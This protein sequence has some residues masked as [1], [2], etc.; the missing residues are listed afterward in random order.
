M[1]IAALLAHGGGISSCTFASKEQSTVRK[2]RPIPGIT[3]KRKATAIFLTAMFLTTGLAS[4]PASATTDCVVDNFTDAAGSNSDGSRTLRFCIENAS[5]AGDGGTI[6]FANGGVDKVI[7]L[8]SVLDRSGKGVLTIDGDQQITV[9][10]ASG[11]TDRLL[12]TDANI[13]ITGMTF[14]DAN[15]SSGSGGAI[16]ASGVVTIEDSLFDNN[17]ASS[18]GG[19]I[20][21]SVD[22]VVKNSRFTNNEAGDDGGAIWA[23]NEV[24]VEESTFTNN[25]AGTGSDNLG[26]AIYSDENDGVTITN[27]TFTQNEAGDDGGAI[28]ANGDVSVENSTFSLNVSGE[29]GGAIWVDGDMDIADGSRFIS[30]TSTGDGG[31]ING[32]GELDDSGGSLYMNNTSTAGDGGAIW[33]DEHWDVTE[34]SFINNEATTGDGGAVYVDDNHDASIVRSYFGQNTAGDDG[35]AVSVAEDLEIEN[36]TFFGNSAGDVGGAVHNHDDDNQDGHILY[37]T[38][39]SNTSDTASIIHWEND[40]L[41][42]FGNLFLNH[43]SNSLVNAGD[44][45]GFEDAGFNVATAV[46][47]DLDSSTSRT[48]VSVSSLGLGT[49][50]TAT[51]SFR[52]TLPIS[53]FANLVVKITAENITAA[54][55]ATSITFPT[56]DQNGAARVTGFY[57]GAQ[58]LMDPVPYSGPIVSSA[59]TSSF[60]VAIKPNQEI[61]LVGIRLS[62]VSKAEV[63]GKEFE[64]VSA[65]EKE[66]VLKSP[67]TLNPGGFDLVIFSDSGKLS[68]LDAFEVESAV[69]STGDEFSAWT[70]KIQTGQIKMY[71]KNVVSAGKVQFFVD[72]EEIAWINAADTS[73]PKISLASG[74]PY[75][76]RTVDLKPGKNRLEIRLDGVRVWRA[77]YVPKD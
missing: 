17:S 25:D 64:V 42:L 65:S 36:S 40:D 77:T 2:Y 50:A 26:G 4:S 59:E 1:A 48:N 3:M 30:N 16:S 45:N 33:I 24:T 55:T 22:V 68:V 67:D 21:T 70:K 52:P 34:A 63:D 6:T 31:A 18:D 8:S 13:T 76:V 62:S 32:N 15:F 27:S 9:K 73:D 29:D 28:W 57:P 49:P 37:S 44:A 39:A 43:E 7:E 38:F 71:A 47:S 35:G 41:Y 69:V 58:L 74:S 19:A 61:K 53:F 46:E 66:L 54:E 60:P 23:D 75:L 72:G 51:T 12:L 5:G 14:R 10:P 20:D 11:I 56:V